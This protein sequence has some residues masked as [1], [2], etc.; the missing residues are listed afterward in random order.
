[1]KQKTSGKTVGYKAKPKGIQMG[2]KKI[3]GQ[4]ASGKSG[5]FKQPSAKTVNTSRSSARTQGSAESGKS[6]GIHKSTP[7]PVQ[8]ANKYTNLGTK[9]VN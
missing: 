7:Q 8:Y 2:V 9:F 5:A 4:R 3:K 6:K 1:M